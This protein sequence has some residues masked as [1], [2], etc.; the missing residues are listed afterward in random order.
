[1]A[2]VSAVRERQVTR[3]NPAVAEIVQAKDICQV[4]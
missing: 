3:N 2:A 4:I 1:M